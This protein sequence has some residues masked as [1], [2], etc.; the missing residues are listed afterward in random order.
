M[1]EDVTVM[2]NIVLGV[3]RIMNKYNIIRCAFRNVLILDM[4]IGFFTLS[5][6][7]WKIRS[8]HYVYVKKRGIYCKNLRDRN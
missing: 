7:M 3:C 4:Q 8:Q 2:Q 6:K 5:I 1:D